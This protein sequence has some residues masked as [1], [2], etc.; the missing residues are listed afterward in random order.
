MFLITVPSSFLQ[1]KKKQQQSR[2]VAMTHQNPRLG[3]WRTP[4]P[5]LTA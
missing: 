3:K 5:G 4:D 1:K 2:V